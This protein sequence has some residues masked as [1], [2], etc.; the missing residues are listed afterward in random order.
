MH[1]DGWTIAVLVA[2][3]VLAAVAVYRC[4]MSVCQKLSE[5]RRNCEQDAAREGHG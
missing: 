4:L 1:I 5:C 3:F 2:F